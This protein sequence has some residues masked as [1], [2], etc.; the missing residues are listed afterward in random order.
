MY[1]QGFPGEMLGAQPSL[2]ALAL[3]LELWLESG[4]WL[5]VKSSGLLLLG[6]ISRV[7]AGCWSRERALSPEL[8]HGFCLPS[9]VENLIRKGREQLCPDG[10]RAQSPQDLASL[11]ESPH[12]IFLI[13]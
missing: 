6:H 4:W 10:G 11:R 7:P 8:L 1:V 3:W 12:R 13:V 9:A 5:P 2:S